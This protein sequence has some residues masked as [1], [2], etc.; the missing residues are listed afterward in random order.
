MHDSLNNEAC[1]G[2]SQQSINIF[3]AIQANKP[4][5]DLEF[6]NDWIADDYPYP[7]QVTR[8]AESHGMLGAGG[9]W[10]GFDYEFG[11]FLP[12]IAN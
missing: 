6:Y 4:L 7:N 2:I 10:G 11:L 1:D 12:Y 3:D 8:I 9:C 5:T